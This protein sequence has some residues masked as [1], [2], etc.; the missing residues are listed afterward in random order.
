MT[1]DVITVTPA[2]P[3]PAT[4]L[5]GLYASG[6]DLTVNTLAD[7]AV[8]QLCTPD[9]VPLLSIEAPHLVHHPYEARRLLGPQVPLPE[10]PFWWTEARATG[11]LPEAQRLAASFAG[12]LTSVLGGAVWPPDTAHTDV[13]PLPSPLTLPPVLASQPPA[14]D[15]QTD[16]AS[17]VVQDRPVIALT[18]WLSNALAEAAAQ[19]RALQLV[20][21]PTSRLT[22]PT[23]AALAFGPHRWVVQHPE[24]GYYDGLRGARLHWNDGAFTEQRGPDDMPSVAEPFT[25]TVGAPTPE[26]ERQLALSLRTVHPATADLVLGGALEATWQ[27]LTGAPPT[28]WGT[29]EPVNLPWSKRELT[30]L[31]RTRAQ[32][33]APTFF[34]TLGTPEQPAIATTR[35]VHSPAGIE[36]HTTLAL[37]YRSDDTLPLEI[38][39]ELTRHLTARHNLTTMLAT[40]RPARRDLTATPHA[41]HPPTPV[42]LSAGPPTA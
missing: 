29:A 17:V 18:T 19:G 38:L 36:E 1:K 12:R 34:I 22:L 23:R 7:G 37:G 42:S 21:P 14:V 16:R 27:H 9:G 31:A 28:G 15:I 20:T 6:P 11:A 24:T 40:H 3:D 30:E 33:G 4:L 32:R 8:L 26:G 2:M 39:P 25:T 13:V 35:I 10:G 5:A 41:E